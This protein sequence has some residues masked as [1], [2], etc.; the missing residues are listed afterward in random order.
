MNER[1]VTMNVDGS[2]LILL[3]CGL[4]LRC[5]SFVGSHNRQKHLSASQIGIFCKIFPQCFQKKQ[6]HTGMSC[7]ASA[8]SKGWRNLVL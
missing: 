7:M 6:K 3:Y 5:R 2:T 1:I 4:C 8:V